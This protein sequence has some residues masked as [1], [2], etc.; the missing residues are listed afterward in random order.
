NGNPLWVNVIGTPGNSQLV[1]NI[2]TD[3]AGNTYVSG[4]FIVLSLNFGTTNLTP[5]NPDGFDLFLA[6]YDRQGHLAW[7]RT[8]YSSTTSQIRAF[9]LATDSSGNCYLAGDYSSA[10]G[11]GLTN[12]G[13]NRFYVAKFDTAG[14]VIWARPGPVI[15]DISSPHTYPIA[16]ALAP[17][18][19]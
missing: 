12:E 18:G 10:E 16:I 9:G 19:G 3:D 13:F 1:Y 2:A 17:N 14:N 7:A 11:L 4:H 8:S 6:R 15:A 5:S